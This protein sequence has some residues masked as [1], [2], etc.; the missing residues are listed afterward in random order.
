MPARSRGQALRAHTSSSMARRYPTTDQLFW[1]GYFGASPI[2]QSTVAPMGLHQGGAA[3]R[4]ADCR[5]AVWRSAP[6]SASSRKCWSGNFRISCPRPAM[7][8]RR[9]RDRGR[10]ADDDLADLRV[11]L[12]ESGSP[13]GVR[14][15]G[16]ALSISGR[17]RPSAKYGRMSRANTAHRLRALG[18]GAQAVA[19]AE[20]GEALAVQRLQVQRGAHRAVHVPDRREAALE[21]RATGT[22]SANTEPPTLLTTRSTPLPS[23][24]F[25]TASW[26]SPVRVRMP[27]SQPELLEP[28]ELVR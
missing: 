7:R 1:A 12:H 17:S 16:K 13:T 2:C 10:E 25:S 3:G 22:H 27:R 18:R 21:S 28:G 15:S 8:E 26:K 24:A 11:G 19:D 20:H 6:R 4:R 23:V 5:A 9:P 14:R